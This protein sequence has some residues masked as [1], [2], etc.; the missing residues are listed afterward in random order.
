MIGAVPAS[1]FRSNESTDVAIE[2]GG[3]VAQGTLGNPGSFSRS[4]RSVMTIYRDVACG[5]A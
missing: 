2:G 1:V 5:V 3:A 4:G